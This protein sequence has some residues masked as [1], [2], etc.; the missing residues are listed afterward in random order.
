MR[1]D[2]VVFTASLVP[3]L[4]CSLLDLPFP[5]TFALFIYR[6]TRKQ[7]TG[8]HRFE[9]HRWPYRAQFFDA[10]KPHYLMHGLG[11]LVTVIVLLYYFE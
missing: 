1:L 6:A 8:K 9:T 7:F 10:T 5:S 4:D 2:G 11:R 3:C